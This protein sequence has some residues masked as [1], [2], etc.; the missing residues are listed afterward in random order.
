MTRP[1]VSRPQLSAPQ[2]TLL[3]TVGLLAIAIGGLVLLSYFRTANTASAFE[4]AGY[5]TTD[6]SNIQREGL[7][8]RIETDKLFRDPTRDFQ[9]VELRR[10]FLA[11]QLRVAEAVASGDP[12]L[13]AG[14]EEIQSTLAQYD[15]LLSVLRA[16]ITPEQF[17]DSS[18]FE[19][20]LSRLEHQTK[21]LYDRQ[22]FLPTI[23]LTNF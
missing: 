10:A 1:P 3:V 19:A 5:I 17:A 15:A 13:T 12:Q 18:E 20:I 23:L 7:L 21:D 16:D 9:P 2:I 6:L 11:A 22:D 8:L 4:R 14:L